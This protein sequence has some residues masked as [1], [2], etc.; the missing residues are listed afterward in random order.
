MGQIHLIRQRLALAEEHMAQIPT[1]HQKLASAEETITQLKS[2]VVG[3]KANAIDAEQ[4][5]YNSDI[6][7][8]R[9]VMFWQEMAGRANMRAALAEKQLKTFMDFAAAEAQKT[10]NE[11]PPAPKK[12]PPPP[13]K[14]TQPPPPPKKPTQPKACFY[15]DGKGDVDAQVEQALKAGKTPL[16]KLKIMCTIAG[17]DQA[18]IDQKGTDYKA[19]WRAI[20]MIVHED[21][22]QVGVSPE[23]EALFNC[24]CKR[25]NALHSKA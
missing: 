20:L 3:A 17:V 21:K 8:E 2:D 22:R 15:W 16:G 12:P 4:R 9:T 11:S 1:L 7:R 13:K 18:L 10:R 19:L 25:V 6:L 23:Q 24:I 14:P 5:A